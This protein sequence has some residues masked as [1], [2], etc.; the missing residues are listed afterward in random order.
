MQARAFSAASAVALIA[1]AALWSAAAAAQET[2]HWGYQGEGGPANWGALEADYAA[3]ATGL[4]QSPINIPGTAAPSTLDLAFDY[5]DTTLHVVNNGH[6]IQVNYA[7]GS[8][9]TVDGKIYEIEQFH[10]H[11]PSEHLVEGVAAPIEMHIVHVAEDGSLAVVGVLFDFAEEDNAFLAR[12]WDGLPAH[13]GTATLPGTVNV[14]T[15]FDTAGHVFSYSGS[16]TTPPCLEGVSWFVMEEHQTVSTAQV[17]HFV[18]LLG[19][20]ARPVQPLNDRALGR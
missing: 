20:N 5:R 4:A 3:C 7:A 15:A 2:H 13:E 6:T 11:V 18:E 17:G 10:F 8:T 19:M 12:F 1:G 9:L 16:L 14:G